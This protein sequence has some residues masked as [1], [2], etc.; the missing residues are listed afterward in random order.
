MTIPNKQAELIEY[1]QDKLTRFG[2]SPRGV[3]WNS[4]EAQ[5]NR[6]AQLCKVIRPT[7][8]FSLL[9]YGSGFGTLY[10]YLKQTGLALQYIGYDFVPE[11]VEKGRELHPGDADCV[12]TTTLAEVQPADYAIA[13]GIFNIRLDMSNAD[14]TAN[15]IDVLEKMHQYSTR[16]FS[17]NMLTKYSD[18][19]Y[20]KPHLYYGDPCF[21]FDYCKTHFSKSVALL[22]D[23]G[24][25]DFTILVRK[26]I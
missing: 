7:G 9:D 1:F 17:F 6:F 5:E 8:K 21:F 16:G 14:W 22:H 3:D 15:V 4:N 20:M 26:D 12:F 23:Y 13:S 19:E 25:Y 11:M 2:T 18:A 10:D 24:L